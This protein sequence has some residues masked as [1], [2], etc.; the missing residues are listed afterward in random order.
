MFEVRCPADFVALSIMRFFFLFDTFS[1]FFSH[2][3]SFHVA[4]VDIFWPTDIRYNVPEAFLYI[5]NFVFF[6]DCF[7][8]QFDQTAGPLV[9][10]LCPGVVQAA[11]HQPNR[12]DSMPCPGAF[13]ADV[14]PLDYAA[15]P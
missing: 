4:V 15:T 5:V 7:V 6:L 2:S 12:G 11:S 9:F 3:G 8:Q 14:L 1:L 10:P 13:K